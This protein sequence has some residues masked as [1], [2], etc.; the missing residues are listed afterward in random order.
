VTGVSWL[1]DASGE[2]SIVGVITVR[3][4]DEAARALDLF[5]GSGR[6]G[7]DVDL[8]GQLREMIGHGLIHDDGALVFAVTDRGAVRRTSG[9]AAAMV[10]MGW[11]LTQYECQATSFHLDDHA[12]VTVTEV[13][14]EPWIDRD[15]RVI[16]LRLGLKLA[17][18]VGR[19]VRG[20]AE[21]AS[22]RCIISAGS[23]NGTFR[24]HQL[25]GG[26]SW[27]VENLDD[28]REEMMITVDM[29]PAASSSASA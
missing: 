5:T 10:R 17:S 25:R 4:N 13:D 26:R 27:L 12:P 3:M 6:A 16:M 21:P 7:S 20:L 22:V 2:P 24:F 8:D 1:T 15:D 11:D 19:L 23:T 28:Y 14:G 18:E 9:A 29:V